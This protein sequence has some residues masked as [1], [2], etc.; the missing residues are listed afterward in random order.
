[1]PGGSCDVLVSD[2]GP[3][4]YLREQIAGKKFSLVRFLPNRPNNIAMPVDNR[5]MRVHSYGR[6]VALDSK[7]SSPSS[8]GPS[9]SGIFHV[10]CNHLK[11]SMILI[12]LKL[13]HLFY[14]LERC[15]L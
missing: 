11:M 12:L 15:I 3:S 4:C 8:W 5:V 10:K 9:V 7:I 6:D 14:L 13:S 1:M 2:C